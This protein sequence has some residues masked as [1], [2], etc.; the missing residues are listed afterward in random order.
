MTTALITGASAGLGLAYAQRLAQDGYDLVL[1]ARDGARLQQVADDLAHRFDA[2]TE[3]L[4]ADLSTREGLALAE[5]RLAD[6]SSPVQVLINNAGFSTN[7]PFVSGD[8]A[9]EQA[10][11]DVMVVAVVRLTHAALAGM[12]ERRSGSVIN[13]ASVAGWLPSGTYGAAKAYVIA[14]TQGLRGELRESG[15]RAMVVCPG[16]THTEFHER[17]A[18]DVSSLPDW[19]WLD[20]DRVV[21]DSLR[22]L[23]RGKV[24]SVPSLAYKAIGFGLRHGP[25][26]YRR[27][28]WRPRGRT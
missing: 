27:G 9:L 21:A 24:V 13:V 16:Y 6:P 10:A 26:R 1:V 2:S 28:R 19:L 8:L 7:Q 18:M 22:D 5:R 15:V 3:V 25:T 23:E 12:V 17:A 4:S 11:L 14:F 20:A